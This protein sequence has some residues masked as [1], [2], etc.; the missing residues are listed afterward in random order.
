MQQKNIY[1]ARCER[2]ISDIGTKK[3][4]DHCPYCGDR[5]DG[6]PF[7]CEKPDCIAKSKENKQFIFCPHCGGE[8]EGELYSCKNPECSA[9]NMFFQKVCG[10]T[11]TNCF[12]CL[13]NYK[14]P[15]SKKRQPSFFYF[16]KTIHPNFT[17][18][19]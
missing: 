13:K 2:S 6:T 8:F 17:V 10:F 4:L 3:R 1:C 19:L 16:L 7:G 5:F 11:S 18:A 12:F 15:A 14:G 9:T